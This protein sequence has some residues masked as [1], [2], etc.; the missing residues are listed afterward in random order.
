M[1][2]VP[3]VG[4]G[5]EVAPP[6]GRGTVDVPCCVL[7]KSSNEVGESGRDRS[8]VGVGNGVNVIEAGEV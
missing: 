3:D 2:V 5:M 7:S 6:N 8:N 1:Y 4:V